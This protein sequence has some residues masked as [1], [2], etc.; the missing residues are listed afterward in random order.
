MFPISNNVNMVSISLAST[1]IKGKNT[2]SQDLKV[3]LA[4][5]KYSNISR[6][7]DEREW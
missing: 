4:L 1:R 7:A 2:L 3:S 6:N 5:L